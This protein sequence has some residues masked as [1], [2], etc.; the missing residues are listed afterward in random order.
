V[1]DGDLDGSSVI[2]PCHRSQSD[3]TNGSVL[4]PPTV[5]PVQTYHVRVDGEDVQIEI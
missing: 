3:I 4:N 5:E 1:T 2:C